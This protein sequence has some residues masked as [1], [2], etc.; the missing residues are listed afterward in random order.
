MCEGHFG[1]EMSSKDQP[2]RNTFRRISMCEDG[3][4]LQVET[5]GLL[6]AIAAPHLA[7][8]STYRATSWSFHSEGTTA[9][10]FGVKSSRPD[11]SHAFGEHLLK[12]QLVHTQGICKSH[13]VMVANILTSF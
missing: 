7:S 11:P 1:P 4:S 10:A 12:W 2:L 9:D 8:S 3:L 5:E 6:N 13:A